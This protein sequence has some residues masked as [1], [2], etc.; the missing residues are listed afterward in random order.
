MTSYHVIFL[1]LAPLH[2]DITEKGYST[3]MIYMSGV[4]QVWF[5]YFTTNK[6]GW[7]SIDQTLNAWESTFVLYSVFCLQT[8]RRCVL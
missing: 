3:L 8:Y 4:Q 7:S 1:T 2:S 5:M 6:I